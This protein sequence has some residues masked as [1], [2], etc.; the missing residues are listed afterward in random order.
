M[1]KFIAVG[2]ILCGALVA[3]ISAG[4]YAVNTKTSF[5]YINDG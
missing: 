3:S 4:E 5:E 1:N 2:V